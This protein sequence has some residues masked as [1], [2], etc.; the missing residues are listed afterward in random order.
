MPPVPTG[1]LLSFHLPA[2]SCL[3]GRE[4]GKPSLESSAQLP[5]EPLTR[6]AGGGGTQPLPAGTALT[7]RW[8]RRELTREGGSGQMDLYSQLEALQ[9][10]SLSPHAFP[11]A[12]RFWEANASPQPSRRHEAAGSGSQ[13]GIREHQSSAEFQAAPRLC[14]EAT[15]PSAAPHSSQTSAPTAPLLRQ[16][17]AESTGP[18]R[19]QER[20]AGTGTAP[21]AALP[22]HTGAVSSH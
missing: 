16:L 10:K 20:G 3:P 7:R 9:E 15:G 22:A 11:K 14:L 8:E 21:G 2:A 5:P 18:R 13:A 17:L 6:A 1:S 12:R 19:C 4:L